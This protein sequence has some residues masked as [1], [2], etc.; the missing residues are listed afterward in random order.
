VGSSKGYRLPDDRFLFLS[1]GNGEVRHLYLEQR[2]ETRAITEGLEPVD[3][4]TVSPDGSR[5]LF[6]SSRGGNEQYAITLL[7]LADNQRKEVLAN[8][9]VRYD[10]P[11]WL[12]NYRF[13]YAANEVSNRD[14]YLYLYN[15]STE[16]KSLLVDRPGTHVITDA[17]STD[18]F[19]FYTLLGSTVTI[20]YRY[21]NG[22]VH[23]FKG[24][25]ENR[26]Y[27]PVG[28]W[29]DGRVLTIT[30]E[31][32]DSAILVLID[33]R[34]KRE[35]IF[36]SPF[37]VETA[38]IDRSSREEAV[39]CTNEEGWSTCYHLRHGTIR[40][41]K[42]GRGVITLDHLSDGALVYTLSRPDTVPCPVYYDLRTD[43]HHP[44]GI[45][46]PRGISVER[47]VSPVVKTI[48]SFDNE[49]IPFLLYT[50]RDISPPYHTIVYFHGGPEG[51]SRPSFAP[52]FQYYLSK[53]FAVVLPNVRGSTGYGRRFSELDNYTKRMDA[54]KDVGPI[55]DKL[56][57]DGIAYPDRFIAWGASYGGFMTVASMAWY[58]ERF[59][60]GITVVG[61][62]DF[63]N[64]LTNT[65]PYR[66]SLREAEY[67]PLDDKSF[68]R[69]IS[70]TSMV[71]RIKGSLFI[72]HGANDPRVPVS[73]AYL[74]A[75]RMRSLGNPPEMLIF[76]DEGHG[77]R[78]KKNLL[79]FN[80]RAAAFIERCSSNL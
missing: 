10:S 6:L 34:G 17:K 26:Y 47:F 33:K 37:P 71:D 24:A 25:R 41:L 57:L 52:I 72:A 32:N 13:L 20:P 54:V 39:F 73:D 35:A 66:K 43:R 62:V 7:T 70:P 74:L 18:Q 77:F 61:V 28:Y 59:R 5:I 21:E 58:P 67:G 36:S 38:L 15:L 19:L 2:G 55:L 76:D 23:K 79:L 45:T 49:L 30:D 4:Y 64:F 78:K 80:E 14:F 8:P 29:H 50:P 40:P 53:G 56:I 63:I 69:S 16:K 60:C 75:D 46:D 48:R 31:E 65:R 9:A 11:F 27:L 42:L 44:F 68:L 12:D 3:T 1:R 51:Q 22:K